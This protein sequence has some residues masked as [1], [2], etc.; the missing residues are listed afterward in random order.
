V[1]SKGR[2]T[3]HADKV[4]SS[5]FICPVISVNIRNGLVLFPFLFW[6]LIWLNPKIIVTEG[7]QNTINNIQV[8]FYSLFFN[9]P[10]IVWDLGRGYKDF[11]ESL[12]RKIY[13]FIY[14]RIVKRAKLIYG[15]NSGSRDY[16]ISLGICSD[17]I[18]VLNNTV[19]TKTIRNII[20]RADTSIPSDV[21]SFYSNEKTYIIFVGS[22]LPTKNIEDFVKIMKN[23]D[24]NY[25]LLIIGSGTNEYELQLKDL[26]KGVNHTFLGYK[27]QEELTYYYKT[28]SFCIL[29]G[30]GGLAIN[31]AMAF[32]VP[33]ICTKADG[34]ERDLILDDINGYIYKDIDDLTNYVKSKTKDDWYLMGKN[35]KD[36]LYSRFTIEQQTVDFIGGINQILC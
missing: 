34:A 16:F 15:Y 24:D 10:Y 1:K 2:V 18:I 11:G 3:V 26:F 5:K 29:P 35:A 20:E 19:D 8:F 27:R 31:Q 36:T 30:L 9:K 25:H 7:G 22:L 6:R 17:K 33:V 28:A 12:A 21:A 4:E 23:L 14:L 32:G 13:L